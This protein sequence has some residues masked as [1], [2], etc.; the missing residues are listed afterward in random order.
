LSKRSVSEA[1]LSVASWRLVKT[2]PCIAL[3]TTLPLRLSSR[4]AVFP[5][6]RELRSPRLPSSWLHYPYSSIRWICGACQLRHSGVLLPESN[7]LPGLIL[8]WSIHPGR[9]VAKMA[10]YAYA[11]MHPFLSISHF[12][13][14][15]L[16][17]KYVQLLA[18]CSEPPVS[19][20]LSHTPSILLTSI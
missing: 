7:G 13:I 1:F 19:H 2:S 8:V 20:F 11:F 15:Y 9:F 10:I 3:N 5:G 6:K 18:Q 14:I 16:L 12:V 17:K 4:W